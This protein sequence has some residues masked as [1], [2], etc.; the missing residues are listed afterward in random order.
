MAS[1]LCVGQFVV[2]ILVRPVDGLPVPGT[3][4]RV[5]DI[6]FAAGGGAAN[7][8][9]VLAK[10]GNPVTAVGLLGGDQLGDL[11]LKALQDDGVTTTEMKREESL[12]TAAVIVLV[13]SDGERS[14]LYRE[15]SNEHFSNKHIAPDAFR[16]ATILHVGGAMKLPALDLAALFTRAHAH[17]CRTSLDTDWDTDG[18]WMTRLRPALPHVD[19]LLTN[20]KEGKMLTGHDEPLAIGRALQALGPPV[21]VVKCGARGALLV[22]PELEQAFP[23]IP[24]PVLDTTCAGDAF[25][26]G[27]LTGIC[28]GWSLAQTMRI[29]NAAGA[30]CTTR[31]SH[32]AVVSLAAVE[33]LL[34]QTPG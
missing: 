14:F 20:E 29:A 17:G 1:V 11:V 9:C 2:D 8:A 31:L 30:L 32:R 21:V 28:R 18:R 25:V 22:T 13:G 27:F 15:G 24:V 3:A 23:T 33:A 34:P 10:L 16:D 19:Y 12:S 7:T 26:A 4:N 5:A 6:Q